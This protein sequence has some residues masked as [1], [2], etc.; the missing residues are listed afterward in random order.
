MKVKDLKP[1]QPYFY[2]TSSIHMRLD[3]DGAVFVL[4]TQTWREGSVRRSEPLFVRHDSGTRKGRLQRTGILVVRARYGMT[5]E[6][7]QILAKVTFQQVE[8]AGMSLPAHIETALGMDSDALGT[9]RFQVD[10]VQSRYIIGEW[11]ETVAAR[12]A[13]QQA[14][15][16]DDR[17][18]RL[19]GELRI[20]RWEVVTEFLEEA[21]GSRYRLSEVGEGEHKEFK[22]TD[23]EELVRL[24]KIGRLA[25][26]SD[27]PKI[28]GTRGERS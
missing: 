5:E 6:Q 1:G 9:V 20:E 14:R 27:W 24:A 25:E 17:Q 28:T 16:E 11:D 18:R 26:E 4:S 23:M 10:V 13:E 7:R 8:A 2:E 12:K 3:G 19:R 21:T 22:L 15:L